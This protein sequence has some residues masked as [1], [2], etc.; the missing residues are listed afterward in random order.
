ML[1]DPRAFLWD[2]RESASSIIKFVGGR[3]FEDYLADRMLRS[4]IEREFEIIGEALSQLSKVAPDVARSIPYAPRAV[5]LRNVLIHGYA[6]V[7]HETIWRT[8]QED[9]PILRTSVDGLLKELGET[10]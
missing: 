7:Q 9:L 3:T 10:P 1:R 8:I 5:G 6:V 4:A 2:V